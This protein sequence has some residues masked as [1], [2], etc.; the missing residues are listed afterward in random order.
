MDT[1][2]GMTQPITAAAESWSVKNAYGYCE[3]LARTHYENFTVGSLLIPGKLRRHLYALYAYCRTV[4]DLGDEAAPAAGQ[5]GDDVAAHRLS[6]LDWWETELETCYGGAPSHPVMVALQETIGA[7]GL[8][9]E[10]FL[11]LIEANRMDQVNRRYPDYA[12]L[13]RYCDHSANPVGR[14]ALRLFGYSDSDRQAWS[15]ATCTALQL[16]NFWQ[17]VAR[18]Y[19]KGR[20]YLPLEDLESFGYTEDELAGGVENDASSRLMR[21]EVERATELF[22][23]GAPLA[24]TLTRSARV[25]VALFTRG[26][27]AVLDAIRRQDYRVLR[28]RPVLSR[29]RKAGLFLSTWLGAKLGTSMGLPRRDGKEV[30]G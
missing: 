9:R 6:L 28:Q 11:K 26:G 8:P 13:L 3:R 14:L 16:T 27:M 17:D 10:P 22:R 21:F 5:P 23:E 24:E 19:A 20:I 2:P 12:G 30:R 7:F 15:D 29:R 18:D 1:G 4:D 25:D